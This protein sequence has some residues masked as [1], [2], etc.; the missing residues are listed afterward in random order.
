MLANK[1]S[2]LWFDENCAAVARCSHWCLQHKRRI[3]TDLRHRQTLSAGPPTPMQSSFQQRIR[4]SCLVAHISHIPKYLC[5]G[6]V[7]LYA[8]VKARGMRDD[9]KKCDLWG[10]KKDCARGVNLSAHK[11]HQ[12]YSACWN[13]TRWPQKVSVLWQS[14]LLESFSLPFSSILDKERVLARVSYYNLIHQYFT[15]IATALK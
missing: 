11:H 15:S 2:R 10:G 5:G 12:K 8:R 6:I 13:P 9:S 3:L 1:T 14:A 7:W 4:E